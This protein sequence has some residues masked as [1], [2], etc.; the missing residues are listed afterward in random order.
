[1]KVG[2]VGFGKT[3]KPVASVLLKNKEI[4]LEWVLRKTHTLEHR[5]VPEFLGIE[6]DEPGLIYSIQ[7]ISIETLL[8]VQPVDLIID[9]ASP[10]AIYYYGD[11]AAKRKVRIL[12]A[13]S[14]YPEETIAKLKELAKE[15]VVFWSPNITLGIN[16]LIIVAKYLKKI[17][18]NVDFVVIEEHFKGKKEMSGTAKVIARE[19]GVDENE[20]KSIRAGGIIGRHE[21]LCGFPYQTIRLIH[22]SISREAFGNGA[23]FVALNLMN[24]EPGFYHFEE[25]LL[26][27]FSI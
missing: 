1:M 21:I 16:Y 11:E 26:P 27:Y 22:E 15:T 2:L 25:L 12:S 5:S 8:D 10:E 13:I 9:F 6:S 4:S 23:I 24:K 17:A 7:D 20:I 14:H 3:G 18:P 19:L